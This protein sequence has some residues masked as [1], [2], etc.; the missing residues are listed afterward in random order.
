MA[1]DI[2]TLGSIM[3]EALSTDMDKAIEKFGAPL[4]ADQKSS[5]K[6]MSSSDVKDVHANLVA[7]RDGLDRLAWFDN[8]NN[9]T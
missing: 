1:I 6:A 2:E 3:D 8:N 7:A 5:L 4:S 9:N